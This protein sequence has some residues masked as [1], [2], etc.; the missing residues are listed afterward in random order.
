MKPTENRRNES[1]RSPRFPFLSKLWRSE[2]VRLYASPALFFLD[3]ALLDGSLR[4]I[5]RGTGVTSVT[6]LIPWMFT[7]SWC[8]IIT[9]ILLL[10]P[11]RPRQIAT[12]TVGG[13]FHV[14]FLTNAIMRRAKGN[15]FSF[16]SLM[17]AADGFKFLD[18]SYLQVRKM[19]WII[20]VF[21]IA[22]LTAAVLL[23]PREKPRKARVILSLILAAVGILGINL[24]RER[25]LSD[26][27]Q[28]HFNIYHSSLLYENFSNPN[29]CVMLCGLYQYTF[30]DF[31]VTYGIYDSLNRM[32]SAEQVEE[33]DAWYEAKEIDPDNEWTGRFAGKNLILIQ[34]EAIDSWMLNEQFMPNLCAI[35]QQSLDFTRHY[36]PLY[37]D[38][39]TFNTEMIVNTGLVSPFVGATSSM[40]SRNSYP[41]S[42]ANL[43]EAAGYTANSFHR[44]TP[45][46]YNRGEIHENWGYERY[47]SGEDMGIEKLDFDEELMRAYDLIVGEEPFLSF[48]ITY[49]GHGAYVGSEVSEAY[50]DMAAALLPEGT[51][52][53]IIHAMAHAWATD[54]FIG[55]LYDRLE[56]EGRLEDTVLVFYADH[57]NYYVLDD[58]LIMEQKGIF[59][60]NLI[61]RTPFFI[62]EK[63]TQPEKIEKVTSTIDV[64]PTL[65]N[66]FGLDCDGR[67]Y[68]GNDAFSENGGYVIFKDYSWYDG[69][70]Y[71]KTTAST[72]ERTEAILARNKEISLRLEMSWNTMKLNY[73]AG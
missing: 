67:Y 42:L 11:R 1:G 30:R 65:V 25:N 48:I 10:L 14:L 53:M 15:F 49:S 62:Y 40:Y 22:V 41:Y 72:G 8:L 32:S 73:F 2:R 43:M 28:N 69:E 55:E 56:A 13:L 17:Y 39:G 3:M 7:L 61:T 31:C 21:S 59:D 63:N 35:Q 38:A 57:Y 33:L 18:A 54:L 50:Y 70:T 51:D 45:D 47:Y 23:M 19:V 20:L 46:V 68:V 6:S 34:L 37:S 36:T 5:H 16:S 64:L 26:R 27:L 66:L 24:N 71:W 44:S 29:E 12:A 60:S 52:E 58:A 9:G 4:L